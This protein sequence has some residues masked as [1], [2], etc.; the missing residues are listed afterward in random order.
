MPVALVMMLASHSQTAPP[1]SPTLGTEN[2]GGGKMPRE[3]MVP[4]R[5]GCGAAQQRALLSQ[6]LV[7]STV[8]SHL[9]V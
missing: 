2:T 7:I 3:T 8:T 9:N 4:L 5:I 6:S 1:G